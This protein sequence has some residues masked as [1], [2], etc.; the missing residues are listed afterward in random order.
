MKLGETHTTEVHKYRMK[1]PSL[2][3]TYR[4]QVWANDEWGNSGFK[5]QSKNSIK[6]KNIGVEGDT[7]N[8]S[9]CKVIF[10]DGTFNKQTNVWMSVGLDNSICPS[11]YVA[12]TPTLN[13]SA[14]STLR[15][16]AIVQMKS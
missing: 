1:S 9:E 3:K 10:P 11:Q 4:F 2:G 15:K 14:E 7:M 16:N 6:V 12:T 5:T 13:I 8:L